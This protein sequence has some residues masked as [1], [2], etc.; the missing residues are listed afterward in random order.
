MMATSQTKKPKK[1]DRIEIK[2]NFYSHWALY[3]GDDKVIHLRGVGNAPVNSTSNNIFSVS[4]VKFDKA[5]VAIDV[6]WDVIRDDEA[7]V[8]NSRDS[9]WTPLDEAKIISEALKHVG[10]VK[11]NIMFANCE[12]F[13]N[14]CRYRQWFSDQAD[15]VITGLALGTTLALAAGA[16]YAISRWG[17]TSKTE[18]HKK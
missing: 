1:G 12:N 9:T 18:K 14:W 15:D 17:D 16:I 7:Y 11:Y 2:R 8:N 5:E 6:I 10:R 4:G 13:V 3:I